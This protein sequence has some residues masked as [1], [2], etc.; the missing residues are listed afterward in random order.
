[1]RYEVVE[2]EDTDFEQRVI[3][4]KTQVA[5]RRRTENLKTKITKRRFERAT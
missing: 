2:I 3:R 5:Q 4:A 1:M